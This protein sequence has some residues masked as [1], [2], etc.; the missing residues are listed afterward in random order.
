[1][2]NQ[3]VSCNACNN[4][5][6]EGKGERNTRFQNQAIIM[7]IQRKYNRTISKHLQIM[8]IIQILTVRVCNIPFFG[9]PELYFPEELYFHEARSAEGIVIRR[10][11]ITPLGGP[12][13][14][15]SVILDSL[16]SVCVT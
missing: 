5:I 15:I 14:S 1:M 8:H 9:P 3:N 11:N 2:S 13:M 7:I 16:D 4:F 10:E 12:K 6:Y